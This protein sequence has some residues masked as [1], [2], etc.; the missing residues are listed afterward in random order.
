M[1]LVTAAFVVVLTSIFLT[2]ASNLVCV[3]LAEIRFQQ[4]HTAEAMPLAACFTKC[5]PNK[6][7]ANTAKPTIQLTTFD[8]R[9]M[10]VFTSLLS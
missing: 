10:V 8:R 9:N 2:P 1:A 3:A 6:I 4:P 7:P 5:E